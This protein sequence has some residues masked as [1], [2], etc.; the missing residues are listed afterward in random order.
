MLIVPTP[1]GAYLSAAWAD[2]FHRSQVTGRLEF[3]FPLWPVLLGVDVA[4]FRELA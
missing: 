3:L 2:E 1:H 4:L